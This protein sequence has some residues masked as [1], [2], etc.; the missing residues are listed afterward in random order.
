MGD[1]RVEWVGGGRVVFKHRGHQFQYVS[2]LFNILSVVTKSCKELKA[3]FH[4]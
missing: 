2:T 1:D 3:S 4:D